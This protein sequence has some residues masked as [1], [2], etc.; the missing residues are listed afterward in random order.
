MKTTVLTELMFAG[1]MTILSD[2]LT[3][4]KNTLQYNLGIINHEL[5]TIKHWKNREHNNINHNKKHRRQTK[6]RHF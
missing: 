5:K 3:Q 4:A 2:N 6:E 1:V